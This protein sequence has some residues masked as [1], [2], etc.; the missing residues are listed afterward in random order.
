MAGGM[1]GVSPKRS[2]CPNMSPPP[3]IFAIKPAMLPITEYDI[4]RI[5]VQ[6]AETGFSAKYL[7]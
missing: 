3:C 5:V 4:G 7:F 2:I 6:Q 1:I